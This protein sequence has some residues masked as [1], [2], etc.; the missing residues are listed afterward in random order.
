MSIF[1]TNFYNNDA[2]LTYLVPRPGDSRNI[3]YAAS[4]I[5]IICRKKLPRGRS[6]AREQRLFRD[7]V[8]QASAT[9]MMA[10]L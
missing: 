2:Y 6:S 4:Q 10:I 9:V 8:F 5:C 3:S 7:A 1:V